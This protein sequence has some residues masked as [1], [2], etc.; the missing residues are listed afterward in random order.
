MLSTRVLY[1]IFNQPYLLALFLVLFLWALNWYTFPTGTQSNIIKRRQIWI[2]HPLQ[3]R[4]V[5]FFFSPNLFTLPALTGYQGKYLYWL[6]KFNSLK[7]KPWL[8]SFFCCFFIN[9]TSENSQEKLFFTQ[10]HPLIIM[11]QTNQ[12]IKMCSWQEQAEKGWCT[13]LFFFF[14]NLRDFATFAFCIHVLRSKMSSIS[15]S[16]KYNFTIQYNNY[17][18]FII[19]QSSQF[20]NKRS[21]MVLLASYCRIV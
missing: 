8:S 13:I 6:R 10:L 18:L 2:F 3:Q 9:I 11:E 5:T 4:T 17:I 12:C 1:N 20:K 19:P 21:L 16:G 14:F 7:F 15:E